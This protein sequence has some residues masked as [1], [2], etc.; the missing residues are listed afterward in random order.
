M[1]RTFVFSLALTLFL[2]LTPNSVVLGDE[3][4]QLD[5][6]ITDEVG[7]LLY[8]EYYLDTYSVCEVLDEETSC[9]IAILVV[10]ST[11]D[12]DISQYAIE[13]FD[14]NGI[15]KEGVK[16]KILSLKFRDGKRNG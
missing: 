12:M 10:N 9:E 2:F 5:D 16:S 4:P 8:S 3:I 13:V 6:F 7:V 15:G 14:S 1:R 11:G